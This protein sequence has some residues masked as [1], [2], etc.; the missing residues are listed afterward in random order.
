V[1]AVAA[2]LSRE[3][4][5]VECKVSDRK[6][7]HGAFVRFP[8]LLHDL[9]LSGR[10]EEIFSVKIEVDTRPPKGAVLATTIVRR[11]V[12]LH[13][14]HHDQASLLAGKLHALLQRPF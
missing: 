5:A 11:H 12:V 4:Y 7:V 1:G 2:E 10:R 3:G 9:A 13:L 14:Q 8:G 6:V